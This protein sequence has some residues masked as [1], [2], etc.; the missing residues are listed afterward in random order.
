M[1]GSM[2]PCPEKKKWFMEIF[3]DKSETVTQLQASSFLR[4]LE[5]DNI[6]SHDFVQQSEMDAGSNNFKEMLNA[7]KPTAT[8]KK[9]PND[10]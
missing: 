7:Q 8:F 4:R 9:M 5:F 1:T 2:H 10:N 3:S 6:T